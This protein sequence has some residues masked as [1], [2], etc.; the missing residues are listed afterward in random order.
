[1]SEGLRIAVADDEKSVREYL[2]E[3]LPRLGHQ[4]V[5]AEDGRQLIE[6]CR[7]APPDLI[8]TDIRMGDLDGLEAAATVNREQPVPVILVTAYHDADLR[9]RAAEDYVMAYL[10]KPVKQAD[11]ETAIDLAMTRFRQFR[12][13]SCEAAD[14]RQALEDRKV[15][16]RAKGVLIKRLH[17]DEAEAFRRLNRLASVRNQKVVAVAREVLEG[18]EVFTALEDTA[19]PA[20]RPR[21]RS[22][23]QR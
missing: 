21:G 16:E 3:L 22:V 9:A 4:V 23:G 20:G 17:L 19:E 18:N 11:L 5:A 6:L 12:A 10:V 7:A 2:R 15:V 8:I 14:L 1:M 13:L